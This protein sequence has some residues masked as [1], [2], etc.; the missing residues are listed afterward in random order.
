MI[1][2]PKPDGRDLAGLGNVATAKPKEE[3]E[4]TTSSLLTTFEELAAPIT[5][6]TSGLGRYLRQNFDNMVDVEKAIAT[7][8]LE[9]ALHRAKIRCERDMKQMHQPL[10]FF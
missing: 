9:K 2:P 4:R 6:T 7:Y 5:E 8:T 1:D 3:F 10:F